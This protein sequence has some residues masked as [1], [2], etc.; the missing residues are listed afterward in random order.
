MGADIL[1]WVLLG[2]AG[3]AVLLF[4]GWLLAVAS[5]GDWVFAAQIVGVEI[6]IL[7]VCAALVWAMT[8]VAA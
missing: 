2:V 1:A 7:G 6:L 5:D 8:R 4:I 3:L